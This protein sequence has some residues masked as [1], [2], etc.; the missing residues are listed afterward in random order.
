MRATATALTIVLALVAFGVASA[1]IA[2]EDIVGYWPLDDGSGDE[3]ADMSGNEH[4]GAVTDGD[5][6]AGRFGGGLQ[7]NGAST[8]IEVL[9]H[10]NLNLGDQF[11]LAAWA[12]TNLLPQQHIGLPRKEAEYV[13]HPTEGGAA[14]NLRFY[15][16]QGGA[17]AAP[18]I[19]ADAVL[20]GDWAHIA[21][22]Y[23]GETVKTWIDGEVNAEGALTGDAGPTTNNLRWSNDCCGGR[24]YDGVLDELAI[25]NRALTEDEM[26]A[27]MNDGMEG[28]LSV[29]PFGKLA[30]QWAALR[31]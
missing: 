6:V 13:L 28:A 24:M 10:E 31:R 7:F 4:H 2:E 3:A 14:Y 25:F 16:G 18:V 20:Y 19:S 5:W 29:R 1:D 21:G 12:M 17:W 22:T 30:T 11:T 26:Q 9:H 27:L 15:V 23:D 8:F